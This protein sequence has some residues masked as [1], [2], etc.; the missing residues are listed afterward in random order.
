MFLHT[1]M[2]FFFSDTQWV[3]IRWQMFIMVCMCSPKS[4]FQMCKRLSFYSI[5]QT[6]QGMTRIQ[7]KT[8]IFEIDAL[9]K[10]RSD[11]PV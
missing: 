6:L 8:R 4:C 5:V 7:G 11:V 9:E 3:V 1:F 2:S 10:Q